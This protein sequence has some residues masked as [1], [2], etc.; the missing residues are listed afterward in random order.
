MRIIFCLLSTIGLFVGVGC[1]PKSGSSSAPSEMTVEQLKE[2]GRVVYVSSCIACH[3]VDPSKDGSLGPAVKGSSLELLTARI[4]KAAY[5][6]NYKPKRETAQM[7][8]LPH[9]EKEIP[10][11]HAYLSEN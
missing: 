10:A 11:I 1:T 3:N 5:P 7:P 6:P 8:A 4:L 2:R 9:L